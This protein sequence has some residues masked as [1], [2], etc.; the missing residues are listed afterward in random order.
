[1]EKSLQKPLASSLPPRKKRLSSHQKDVIFAWLML[2][3]PLAQFVIFWLIPNFESLL[4]C[5]QNPNT[6]GF[7]WMNFSR[8]WSEL[9]KPESSLLLSIRNTLI[10]FAVHILI[11]MPIVIFF[12][13]VLYKKILGYKIFRVIFY[14]PSIIGGTVTAALFRYSIGN[15]GPIEAVLKWLGVSFD[16]QL[17]LLGNPQTAFAMCVIYSLWVGVGINM[18]MF[19]G[20][21]NRLPEE[22]FESARI[23]GCGFWRQFTQIVV[24]LI[25]PTIT[26]ML[27]FTMSS[28]FVTYGPVMLLAPET[29]EASMIG[30][31][32]I[33]YTMAAGNAASNE[34]MNYPATVGLIFTLIGFPLTLL[35]K[36]VCEKM[37]SNVEY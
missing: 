4:L 11:G 25:W 32:I 21:M 18:I 28:I 29:P 6:D 3:L 22:V 13:Y 35:V 37:G 34:V 2:A 8:F 1:M 23:D 15:G 30:W 17:G 31:Y 36:W 24:P 14:L 5:F 27:I 16:Q 7:T 20:A 33:R 9:V 10:F 19:Y 26:T 12:S